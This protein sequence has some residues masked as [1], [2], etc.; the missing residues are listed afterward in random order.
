[1][2]VSPWYPVPPVG[3]GGI[4]LMAYQLAR[5]LQQRG[6]EVSVIGQQGSKGPFETIAIAPESWSSQLGTRDQVPRESLFLYRAYE[7]VRRRAFDGVHDHSGIPGLLRS[8]R[9]RLQTP[10]VT[11][12]PRDPTEPQ[13][14]IPA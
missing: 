4:E 7:L 14:E 12:H 8:A 10:G 13:S 6:H 2:I 1:M 3:Y 11:T 5:E 9:T